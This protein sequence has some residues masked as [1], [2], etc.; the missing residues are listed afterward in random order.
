MEP[1]RPDDD[2]LR[3]DPPIG[4]VERKKPEGHKKASPVKD[5]APSKPP[6]PPKT[7]KPPRGAGGHS[8]GGSALVWLLFLVVAAGAGAG[9]Y[10]QEKRIQVLEGQLEEADYGARQSK[11]ALARFE[12]ELSETGESL[13]ERGA[14]LEERIAGN[15]KRLDEA[16]SEIRKLWV[17]ANERNKKRLDEHQQLLSGLD[18]QLAETVKSVSDLNTT[19]EQARSSLAADVA[20]LKQQLEGSVAALERANQEA[21]A[22]LTSVSQQVGDV[23]QVVESQIRRFEREQQLTISGL[24]SQ[25]SALQRDL[26]AMAGGGD[27]QALRTQLTDLK[28]TVDSVDSSR[29]QLTSRLIRLSEEVNQLRSEVSA[30]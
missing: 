21:N 15:D 22:Q 5:D 20:Q 13:Q 10:L 3:A 9:W 11:L 18:G 19:I 26:S 17:I 6:K 24:E 7:P 27:V 8:G 28:R 16:D 4:G 12:G 14:S 29:S 2:E 30:R 1:I 25:I 23:D